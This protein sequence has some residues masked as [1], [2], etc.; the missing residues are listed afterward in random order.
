[1]DR[2]AIGAGIVEAISLRD[3]LLLQLTERLILEDIYRVQAAT[4]GLPANIPTTL[5]SWH[6][7][8]LWRTKVNLNSLSTPSIASPPTTSRN[9]VKPMSSQ[10]PTGNHLHGQLAKGIGAESVRQTDTTHDPQQSPQSES[11][12]TRFIFTTSS[13]SS[14]LHLHSPSIDGILSN[15]ATSSASLL[16]SQESISNLSIPISNMQRQQLTMTLL[17]LQC[18]YKTNSLVFAPSSRPRRRRRRPSDRIGVDNDRDGILLSD[19]DVSKITNSS[20]RSRSQSDDDSSFLG[21]PSP[22]FS[23]ASSDE[24][25]QYGGDMFSTLVSSSNSHPS[26][27][28][29]LPQGPILPSSLLPVELTVPFFL[30]V[31]EIEEH[32]PLSLKQLSQIDDILRLDALRPFIH[33]PSPDDTNERHQYY[34]AV[35]NLERKVEPHSNIYFVDGGGIPLMTDINLSNRTNVLERSQ[36]SRSSYNNNIN[37]NTIKLGTGSDVSTISTTSA[38]INDSL[39]STLIDQIPSSRQHDIS[40][41]TN[42]HPDTSNDKPGPTIDDDDRINT[43]KSLLISNLSNDQ[44]SGLYLQLW[45]SAMRTVLACETSLVHQLGVAVKFHHS[46]KSIP[47]VPNVSGNNE[48]LD[49]TTTFSSSITTGG[50]ART[51]KRSRGKALKDVVGSTS[52]SSDQIGSTWD[53]TNIN[54]PLGVLTPNECQFLTGL[55]PTSIPSTLPIASIRDM[56]LPVPMKAMPHGTHANIDGDTLSALPSTTR[57]ATSSPSSPFISSSLCLPPLLISLR[58]SSPQITPGLFAPRFIPLPSTSG[59]VGLNPLWILPRKAW[60]MYRQSTRGRNGGYDDD[61][62]GD[63]DGDTTMTDGIGMF[64]ATPSSCAASQVHARHHFSHLLPFA[65]PHAHYSRLIGLLKKNVAN[66]QPVLGLSNNGSLSHDTRNHHGSHEGEHSTSYQYINTNH[67]SSVHTPTT[68]IDGSCIAQ[69]EL[70]EGRTSGKVGCLSRETFVFLPIMK[71]SAVVQARIDLLSNLLQAPPTPNDTAAILAREG[72]LSQRTSQGPGQGHKQ[73]N[74][75]I[76]PTPTGS[77]LNPPSSLTSIT[78]PYT[79][80]TSSLPPI[81]VDVVS[82]TRLDVDVPVHHSHNLP[83]SELPSFRT[84]TRPVPPS[85]SY[86]LPRR[87]PSHHRSSSASS[88]LSAMELHRAHGDVQGVQVANTNPDPSYISASKGKELKMTNIS[89]TRPK[90]S[91]YSFPSPVPPDS[92]HVASRRPPLPTSVINSVI[93][94][95]YPYMRPDSLLLPGGVRLQM[96]SFVMGHL[97]RSIHNLIPYV[98]IQEALKV[99]NKLRFLHYYSLG[100]YS[101]FIDAV[102][103]N[104]LANLDTTMATSIDTSINT[105]ERQS[106]V[107]RGRRL[108]SKTPDHGNMSGGR[109]RPD[110]SFSVILSESD[111]DLTIKPLRTGF[112]KTSTLSSQCTDEADGISSPEN[113]I[114]SIHGD[115]SVESDLVSDLDEDDL[116]SEINVPNSHSPQDDYDGNL[117]DQAAAIARN[118]AHRQ[119]LLREALYIHVNNDD[120]SSATGAYISLTPPILSSMKGNGHEYR[121]TAGV[122]PQ[123]NDLA[124][125]PSELR[126]FFHAL[127][128]LPPLTRSGGISPE[129]LNTASKDSLSEALDSKDSLKKKGDGSSPEQSLEGDQSKGQMFDLSTIRLSSE[130]ET[131]ALASMQ[132]IWCLPRPAAILSLLNDSRWAAIAVSASSFLSLVLLSFSITFSFV[133]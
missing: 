26:F 31:C 63:D 85:S 19:S 57:T 73:N 61:N 95:V 116:D 132:W 117:H 3:S 5:P 86:L 38:F 129:S 72:V 122:G 40:T 90:V 37:N 56:L 22:T 133:Y 94:V 92:Y 59:V 126:S 54:Y 64:I 13:P 88:A 55:S 9:S 103:H 48:T 97:T 119:V 34:Y 80:V 87:Q 53:A 51:M 112:P 6:V 62:G 7:P 21:V 2:L 8:L 131:D 130:V 42:D 101:P 1:M 79:D 91:L 109:S 114:I 83:V 32:L 120:P 110:G 113:D 45:G 27:Q 81:H 77:T 29:L 65:A 127:M 20:A 108:S 36:R 121:R 93:S 100:A 111:D 14:S 106:R 23:Q 50:R 28:P 84:I 33:S 16:L 128:L 123:K 43:N 68:H 24:G 115:E 74:N 98:Y 69:Y 105:D 124:A 12:S 118:A 78:E 99:T 17:L 70:S 67:L 49:S 89:E 4:I 15:S 71:L 125:L 76:S 66:Q 107:I 35:D 41:S 47:S 10:L 30:G 46:L 11:T 39:H 102:A 18:G 58:R 82:A 52:K 44:D 75:V 104:P 60:P 96:R 25:S